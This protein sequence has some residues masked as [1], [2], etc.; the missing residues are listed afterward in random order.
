M[1]HGVRLLMAFGLLPALGGCIA[2]TALDVVTAPVKVVSKGVDLATTSQ[3]ESDEKRGRA[4][5]EREEQIGKLSRKRDREAKRCDDG[6]S[7]ACAKAEALSAEIESL[8][9]APVGR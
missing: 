9:D 7:E 2:K 4:L 3:S 1:K 6:N 8:V 5:R